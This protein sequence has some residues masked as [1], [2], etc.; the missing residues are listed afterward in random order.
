MSFTPIK[1]IKDLKFLIILPFM[2]ILSLIFKDRG[3]VITVI[4][5]V[6]SAFLLAL[7][8]KRI[9]ARIKSGSIPSPELITAVSAILLFASGS[10]SASAVLLTALLGITELFDSGILGKNEDKTS[11]LLPE[12]KNAMGQMMIERIAELAAKY[13]PIAVSAIT[14]VFLVLGIIIKPS[15]WREVLTGSSALLISALP[16]NIAASV[17]PAI[18]HALTTAA[19]NGIYIK[20]SRFMHLLS[21]VTAVAL[22]K[23]GT[24]TEGTFGVSSVAPEKINGQY[25]TELAALALSRTETPIAKSVREISKG[26][27]DKA[28]LTESHHISGLGVIALISGIKVAVGSLEMMNKMGIETGDV[29][30][31]DATVLHMAIGSMYAGR[32]VIGDN[33]KPNAE[34]A[35]HRLKLGGVES[36]I[37]LT[38]DDVISAA[39]VAEVVHPIDEYFPGLDTEGKINTLTNLKKECAGNDV[40]AFV[41]GTA[42]DGGAAA[43][44]DVNIVMNSDDPGR[45]LKVFDTA[46]S[47]GEINK[48]PMATSICRSTFIAITVNIILACLAK[49]FQ[50]LLFALNIRH[51]VIALALEAA[52]AV[53]IERGTRKIGK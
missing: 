20:N 31:I 50:I 1:Y 23:T 53:F 33:I 21:R 22:T 34:N 49:L 36:I 17:S 41:G 5:S 7:T 3:V 43:I 14:L 39:R 42:E 15:A 48:L 9:T 30:D 37:M 13:L 6:I 12:Q 51:P 52:A 44:A 18:L 46:I 25:M 8:A 38:R 19:E 24:L 16:F 10:R 28:L 29:P 11:L 45:A 27:L 40:L 26:T 2:I 32:I 4:V 35:L 47:D